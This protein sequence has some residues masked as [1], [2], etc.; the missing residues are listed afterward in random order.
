MDLKQTEEEIKKKKWIKWLQEF[1]TTKSDIMITDQSLNL[2]NFFSNGVILF[3]YLD[4]R[5]IEYFFLK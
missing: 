1:N 4:Y 5:N 3:K 2:L